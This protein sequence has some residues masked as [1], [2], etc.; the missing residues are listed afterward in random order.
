MAAISIVYTI[1]YVAE[2]IGENEELLHSLS[3]KMDPEDG[4]L[5][6]FDGKD[7]GTD[8]STTAFTEYGIDCL[9]D[10]LG[11]YRRDSWPLC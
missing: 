11:N 7:D 3:I 5:H 6:V 9:R 10:L 1:R 4:C 8:N 2:L